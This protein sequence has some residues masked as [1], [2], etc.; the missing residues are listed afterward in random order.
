MGRMRW[1]PRCTP[2]TVERAGRE[3]MS[4]PSPGALNAGLTRAVFF[5]RRARGK[6]AHACADQTRGVGGTAIAVFA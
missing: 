1:R 5:H 2:G 6:A 3:G 4:G